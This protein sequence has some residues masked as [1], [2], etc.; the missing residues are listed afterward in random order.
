MPETLGQELQLA[1][2]SLKDSL[3]ALPQ[4]QQNYTSKNSTPLELSLLYASA[5]INSTS[6][7]SFRTSKDNTQISPTY[8]LRQQL[9]F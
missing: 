5:F 4:F 2:S 7:P 3:K 1:I 8:L 6:S 9:N